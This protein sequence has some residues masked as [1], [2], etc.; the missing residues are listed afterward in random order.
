MAEN[1]TLEAQLKRRMEELASFQ[2]VMKLITSTLELDKILDIILEV[3]TKTLGFEFVELDL[4]DEGAGVVRAVRGVNISPEQIAGSV[5]PLDSKDIMADIVRTG[6]TEIIEGWDPRFNQEMFEREGHAAL[7]RVFTPLSVRG[8]NIGLVEAGYN[9]A[10]RAR[11]EEDEVRM[12]QAFVAQAAIAIDNARLF[13]EMNRAMEE[14]KRLLE[15]IQALSTPIVPISEEILILPLVGSIDTRRAGQIMES[16]LEGINHYQAET[17]IIDITGVPVVDT[18]V[19]NHLLQAAQA[20]RLL[21]AQVIL[22]GISPEIA[23]T[24]VELGIDLSEVVTRRNLQQGIAY[25]MK[26]DFVSDKYSL[27]ELA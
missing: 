23:Q 8:K 10:N 16:L 4:V 26:R 1:I 11:I 18:S 20:A 17:V 6:K 13:S 12:L 15:T 19:A 2:E 9:K 3:I 14:Q 7:V 5:R 25:A 27:D 24:I 22:V 21:G